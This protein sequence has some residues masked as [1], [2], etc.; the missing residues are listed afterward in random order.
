LK[1]VH[2]QIC[3][4][5]IKHV[6]KQV[7]QQIKENKHYQK[8]RKKFSFYNWSAVCFQTAEEVQN[9]LARDHEANFQI[10]KGAQ[11]ETITRTTYKPVPSDANPSYESN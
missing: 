8:L 3:D 7:T 5:I 1:L 2:K 4:C 11:S 6:Q 10:Q 9:I